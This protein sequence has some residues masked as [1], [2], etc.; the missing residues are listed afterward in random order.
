MSLKP[1]IICIPIHRLPFSPEEQI[2][3][4]R[5][6][7][8]FKD[9]L[10]VF[11]A[12][13]K[14]RGPYNQLKS[15]SHALF[16]THFFS[17]KHFSSIVSYSRFLL[18][19]ELYHHFSEYEYLLICQP[20]VYVLHDGLDQWIYQMKY[21]Y[22]GAPLLRFQPKSKKYEAYAFNGGFSLRKVSSFLKVLGQIGPRFNRFRDLPAIESTLSRVLGS[23]WRNGLVFNYTIE[24]LLPKMNED[25]IWSALIPKRFPHFKVAPLE[26]AAH[27]AL[28]T[29]IEHLFYSFGKKPPIAIHN[30]LKHEPDA[31]NKLINTVSTNLK[32][33]N[34]LEEN[35]NGSLTKNL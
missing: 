24:P 2:A 34:R 11:I 4:E 33:A 5:M 35:P 7:R 13:E 20:D 12:P 30:W 26:K 9:R 3:I 17:D 15:R 31:A 16:D 21:D 18:Q 22:V 10:C 6:Q 27:F 8:I 14:L 28:E 23:F 29:H 32:Q 1:L 25:M 19:A